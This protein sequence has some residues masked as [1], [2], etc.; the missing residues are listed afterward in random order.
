[1]TTRTRTLAAVAAATLALAACSPP[2][3]VPTEDRVV[4]A[5][6]LSSPASIEKDSATPSSTTT[7]HGDSN[8]LSSTTTSTSDASTSITTSDADADDSLPG[9]INCVSAPTQRPTTLNLAC[10]GNEDRLVDIV[11]LTWGT[12]E[13]TGTATRITNTCD[14][15]CVDGKKR[16]TPDVDVVLNLPRNTPQGIAFTQIIVDG[17]TIAP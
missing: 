17:E 8:T 13:A 9:V 5:T 11:W 12:E 7:K 16:T 14:P 15:T 2:H 6:E 3:E 1:M 10:S 4:T